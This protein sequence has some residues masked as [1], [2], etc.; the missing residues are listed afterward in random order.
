MQ[1]FQEEIRSAYD[2]LSRLGHKQTEIDHAVEAVTEAHEKLTG[3]QAGFGPL[4]QQAEQLM[5]ANPDVEAVQCGS[6][7]QVLARLPSG[8]IA[9]L[10]LAHWCELEMPTPEPPLIPADEAD[11]I[12]HRLESPC[13]CRNGGGFTSQSVAQLDSLIPQ[14]AHDRIQAGKPTEADRTLMA[15]SHAFRAQFD[16]PNED[17]ETP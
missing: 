9:V 16:D 13:L 7:D 3:C 8:N 12:F 6:S 5:Q 14:D 2:L 4:M 11:V 17:E 1:Q 10:K 15:M